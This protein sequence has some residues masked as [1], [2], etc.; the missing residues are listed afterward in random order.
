MTAG[1]GQ[2]VGFKMVFVIDDRM[3]PDGS[4]MFILHTSG[5]LP[6]TGFP[7]A[8][9]HPN[10][11]TH[12]HASHAFSSCIFVPLLLLLLLLLLREHGTLP[13]VALVDLK[14]YPK[15]DSL[16]VCVVVFGI[17]F[18]ILRRVQLMICLVDPFPEIH[19]PY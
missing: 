4:D 17:R 18:E 5:S 10:S 1:P 7:P 13:V 19:I 9:P 12:I 2:L 3:T 6:M 8:V 14:L 11:F 15:K 16:I